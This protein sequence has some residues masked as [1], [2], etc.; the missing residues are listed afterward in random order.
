MPIEQLYTITGNQLRPSAYGFT[1]L[2]SSPAMAPSQALAGTDPL[3]RQRTLPAARPRSHLSFPWALPV[4]RT[5][6]REHHVTCYAGTC[7]Y[8]RSAPRTGGFLDDGHP[9][10]TRSRPT[11]AARTRLAPR[12][13]QPSLANR[14]AAV[15]S[16]TW[17]LRLWRRTPLFQWL[18]RTPGWA[19][20]MG[21]PQASAFALS[22]R[23]QAASA[24]LPP[25][26]PGRRPDPYH[27]RSP[28]LTSAQVRKPSAPRRSGLH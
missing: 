12:R 6:V 16:V 3:A 21:R 2:P 7:G 15:A 22:Q 18:G 13:S 25:P 28:C 14:R 1:N 26:A 20:L 9:H 19:R 24:K 8:A 5:A 17:Y 11:R 27:W 23:A 10:A 4:W